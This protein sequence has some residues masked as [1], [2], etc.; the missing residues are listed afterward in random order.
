MKVLI[1]IPAYNE[2]GNIVRVVDNLIKNYPEYDY[3]VVNDG[4]SDNTK[5]LCLEHHYNL[6]SHKVNLGLASS[7]QTGMK[8]ALKNGYDA[9]LQFDGDGQHRPEYIQEMCKKIRGR[10]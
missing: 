6:L 10:L 5:K 9:V 1:V 2:E 4:S 8:Y 3:V 7:F